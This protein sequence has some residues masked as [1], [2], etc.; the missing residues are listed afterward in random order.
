MKPQE[1]INSLRGDQEKKN[2]KF[3][4]EHESSSMYV[5]LTTHITNLGQ[6]LNIFLK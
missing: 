3:V 6:K 4:F 2:T 5:Q 1:G